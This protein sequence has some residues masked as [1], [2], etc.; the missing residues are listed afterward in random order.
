MI[1]NMSKVNKVSKPRNDNKLEWICTSYLKQLCQFNNN[2]PT[3]ASPQMFILHM[4]VFYWHE[5]LAHNTSKVWNLAF[6]PTCL[7]LQIVK[8]RH[9]K[10]F[11]TF[12]LITHFQWT[13]ISFSS[14]PII[15]STHGNFITLFPRKHNSTPIPSSYVF[16]WDALALVLHIQNH[17]QKGV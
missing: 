5:I 7:F 12:N 4:L 2:G 6:Y 13:I 14:H 10:I 15:V 17:D 3:L 8:L 16:S 1:Q 9:Q 11:H